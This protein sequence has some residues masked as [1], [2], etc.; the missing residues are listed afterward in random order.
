MRILDHHTLGGSP[1]RTSVNDFRKRDRLKKAPS[2]YQAGCVADIAWEDRCRT[3]SDVRRTGTIIG[4]ELDHGDA[5]STWPNT[6]APIKA[7]TGISEAA[8]KKISAA[9]RCGCFDEGQRL[10]AGA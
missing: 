6:V 5:V 3:S 8:R 2:A 1:G 10:N 7:M 4:S 9:T